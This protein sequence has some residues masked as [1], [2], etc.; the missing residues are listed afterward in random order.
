M[1]RGLHRFV[2]LGW[3]DACTLQVGR[4]SHLWRC[5]CERV[6][7]AMP[8][9]RSFALKAI[10]ARDKHKGMEAARASAKSFIEAHYC[11]AL[12]MLRGAEELIPRFP[13]ATIGLAAAATLMGARWLELEMRHR[14]A[15]VDER[16]Y[17]M[18][19]VWSWLGKYKRVCTPW[20]QLTEGLLR[21]H[22]TMLETTF[23]SN[24]SDVQIV[25]CASF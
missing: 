15:L 16:A 9:S 21:N 8:G 5:A 4:L 24:P 7:I 2:L 25:A 14:S 12:P 10:R 19:A 17:A 1:Q 20:V 23:Q 6:A 13:A 3:V 11:S 22:C 18:L